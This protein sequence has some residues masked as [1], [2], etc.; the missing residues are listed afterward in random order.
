MALV[1]NQ[2]VTEISTKNISSEVGKAAGAKGWQ[3]YHIHVPFVL[4]FGSLNLLGPSRPVQ[5]CN[6]IVL[7][8]S[9]A[10][11]LK[12]LAHREWKW[13]LLMQMYVGVE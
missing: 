1:L 7:P 9:V 2:T 12:K 8:L 3:P 13:F 4:K 10:L 11:I 5:A 6:G